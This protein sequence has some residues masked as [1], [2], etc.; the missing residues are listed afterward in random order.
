[1]VFWVFSVER[2]LFQRLISSR[3]SDIMY[4]PRRYFKDFIS[5]CSI[6]ASH[7]VFVEMAVPTV[8][9][10]IDRTMIKSGL[11]SKLQ[12]E[13]SCWGGALF[14]WPSDEDIVRYPCGHHLD[15]ANTTQTKTHF[16]RLRKGHDGR[17]EAQH[18]KLIMVEAAVPMLP[19]FGA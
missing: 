5:L 12:H 6:F 10:I 2:E 18:E 15:L 16:A 1:M 17:W 14:S 3:W 9:E 4:L 8:L 11:S 19:L 7:K 13:P